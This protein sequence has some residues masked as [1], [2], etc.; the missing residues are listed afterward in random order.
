MIIYQKPCIA[1]SISVLRHPDKQLVWVVALAGLEDCRGLEPTDHTVGQPSE[2][3]QKYVFM[4]KCDI[5]FI[6]YFLHS[7]NIAFK[8]LS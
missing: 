4:F 8:Y 7:S 6:V 5:M 2:K 3:T 1:Q